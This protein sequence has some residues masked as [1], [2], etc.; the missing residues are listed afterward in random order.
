MASRFTLTYLPPPQ[1]GRAESIRLV[2]HV[3]GVP[4]D[5]RRISM[6][7]FLS[8]QTDHS[9]FPT[10]Q[11]PVLEVGSKKYT[12]AMSIIRFAGKLSGFYPFDPVEACCVDEA[13]DHIFEVY[14]SEGQFSRSARANSMHGHAGG[15]S[16]LATSS[17]ILAS[18][19]NNLQFQLAD[20][21]ADS[22]FEIAAAATGNNNSVL[23][24]HGGSSGA[25]H[26]SVLQHAPSFSYQQQQQQQQQT[27][28]PR[29]PV[30]AAV[31]LPSSRT[32]GTRSPVPD[33]DFVQKCRLCFRRICELINYHPD[34]S[35]YIGS[36]R[37]SIADFAAFVLVKQ[38]KRGQ[39]PHIPM[40]LLDQPE[41]ALLHGLA[42]VIET[43]PGVSYFYQGEAY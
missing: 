9:L 4:Y 23:G 12:Q 6:D 1:G 39:L 25:L 11:L 41:F 5:D 31:V 16:G 10:E 43:F 32:P 28:Q 21:G 35:P 30:V 26:K 2:L 22:N 34:G 33:E 13:L 37:P 27:G 17:P 14:N 40:T 20:P 24:H 3:G 42:E 18:S 15:G 7:Q 38:I 19:L 36:A 8:R 29:S